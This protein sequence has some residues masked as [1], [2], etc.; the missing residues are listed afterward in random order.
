MTASE[1]I[2]TATMAANDKPNTLITPDLKKWRERLNLSPQGMAQYVGVP[3]N[4]WIKWERGERKPPAS[5]LALF[6]VLMMA[7][8]LAPALH[9]ALLPNGSQ[10]A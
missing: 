4:T 2:K 7:E 8:T 6:Q 5:A 1:L 9:E 10:G 3:H